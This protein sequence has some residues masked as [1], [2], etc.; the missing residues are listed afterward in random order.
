MSTS[1]ASRSSS[2]NDGAEGAAAMM[3]GVSAGD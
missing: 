2:S 3:C 1:V